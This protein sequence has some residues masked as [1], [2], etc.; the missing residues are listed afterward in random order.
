MNIFAVF[1]I[2]I[3]LSLVVFLGLL[4]VVIIPA[5]FSTKGV[6][7]AQYLEE[8][9][10]L[11]VIDIQE[12]FS[13]SYSRNAYKDTDVF[14][15]NVNRIIDSANYKGISVIYIRH[16][17]EGLLGEFFSRVLGGGKGLKGSP[18][19]QIDKRI[20]VVSDYVFTKP[21]GDAFANPEFEKYLITQHINK[22]YLVGLDGCFCVNHTIEGAINRGYKSILIKDGVATSMPKYWDKI[23]SKYN[24]KGIEII[25]MQQF[26]EEN[27]SF[28]T[29]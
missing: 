7:I 18:G 23:L 24:K 2:I 25:T 15:S 17:F 1:L 16:E 29:M 13:G 12:D 27:N 9:S 14:T 5:M 6:K 4:L 22:L 19:S 8:K 10:A 26:I 11:L 21:K 20:K 28:L 3:G